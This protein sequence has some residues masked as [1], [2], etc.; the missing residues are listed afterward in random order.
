MI[1][2]VDDTIVAVSSAAGAGRRGI[3]RLSGPQAIA[4]VARR[5]VA[6]HAVGLQTV[7]GWSRHSGQYMIDAD[8]A[9]PARVELFKEP[10]SYTRQHVVEI[11]T[12]GSP[13]VLSMI[14]ESLLISGAR[15]AEPGEFT[16]RAFLAGAIDL[17]EAEGVAAL[18]QARSDGQLR[19][20]EKLLHGGL[21]A[22]MAGI[23]ST[24]AHLLALVEA[25]IDFSTE[26]IDLV[27]PEEVARQ[28]EEIRKR[29]AHFLE[30]GTDSRRL[31][32]LP[33]V[34][35]TGP[36]NAGKST[37][38]NRLTGLERAICSPLAG[39][40][41]D[42]LTAPMRLDRGDVL[43][44]D[45]PGFRFARDDM[46]RRAGAALQRVWK[47]ADLVL[48]VLDMSIPV[49]PWVLQRVDAAPRWPAL[50]VANKCDLVPEERISKIF[51]DVQRRFD[52]PVVHLSATVGTGCEKLKSWLAKNF[53]FS[54]Q[55]AGQS[56]LIL[57]NRH[58]QDMRR[59]L[60]SIGRARQLVVGIPTISER[61]DLI[62]FELRDALEAIEMLSGKTANEEILGRIFS[63]FCIGK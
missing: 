6:D 14:L 54:R 31:E 8:L 9:V 3:V 12:V 45:A 42:V 56:M 20:A 36:P 32:L 39:T 17:T 28:L 37:L 4:L 10:A 46:D 5:F 43:L 29:L 58:R 47:Q 23:R 61:A 13:P 30:N 59:A 26:P 50:V 41:R 63:R 52:R 18:I 25:D 21:S 53:F 51:F 55:P 27:S 62:A 2:N 16:A 44:L 22:Q 35:L 48:L 60:Q 33:T 38:L 49:E 34:L 57:N 24:L 7:D 11:H 15:A 19:A 40:T 1:E